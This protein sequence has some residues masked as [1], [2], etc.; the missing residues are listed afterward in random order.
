MWP[1]ANIVSTVFVEC[2]SMY[3][4]DGPE[5][6]K[7]VG[8]TEFVQGI[9]V[10]SAS[11]QYGPTRVALGIVGHA[12]VTLGA[13]IEPVLEAHPAA[14]PKPLPRHTIFLPVGP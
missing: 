12:D 4:Q 14:N 2:R 8:E 6:M 1:R 7:P 9:A 5:A 10:R 13:A 11:G 3:R